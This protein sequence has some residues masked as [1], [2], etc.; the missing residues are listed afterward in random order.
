[1]T[2]I[3]THNINILKSNLQINK[4]T[5]RQYP[6]KYRSQIKD[7]YRNIQAMIKFET[8]KSKE[9]ESNLYNINITD[10]EIMFSGILFDFIDEIAYRGEYLAA[11]RQ[12]VSL[13]TANILNGAMKATM[14]YSLIGIERDKRMERKTHHYTTFA[15]YLRASTIETVVK[16]QLQ[17]PDLSTKQRAR[18]HIIMAGAKIAMINILNDMD[19]FYFPF[20]MVPR[21]YGRYPDLVQLELIREL[22]TLNESAQNLPEYPLTLIADDSPLLQEEAN[23]CCT[24]C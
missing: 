3:S 2:I 21:L 12:Q 24:L 19:N 11:T 17:R 9:I 16:K 4:G 22:K 10:K 1:M 8:A 13:R 18:L 7:I 23:Q 6:K 14:R 20:Y 5:R 15:N